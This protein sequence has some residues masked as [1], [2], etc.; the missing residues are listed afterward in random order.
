MTGSRISD[1]VD[2]IMYFSM[3]GIGVFTPIVFGLYGTL[4]LR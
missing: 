4:F 1:L 3:V 2:S